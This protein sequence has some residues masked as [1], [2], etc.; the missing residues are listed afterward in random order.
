MITLVAIMLILRAR[1][2][3]CQ[4]DESFY[5][6]LAQR[7]Y[8]GD[9]LIIDEWHPAQFY[10]P[11]LLP[12][13]AAYRALVPSQTGILFAAR[14]SCILI[15]YFAALLSF[16]TA[17]R[18][19]PV[20]ASC[21]AS[22]LYLVYA[23]QNI[24]GFSYYSLFSA[25]SLISLTLLVRGLRG[26]S[27]PNYIAAGLFS[28]LTVLCMP[29]SAPLFILIG[30]ALVLPQGVRRKAADIG[31]RRAYLLTIV[32]SA[33][34]YIIFFIPKVPVRT[35]LQNLQYI[36]N[37]PEHDAS[38]FQNALLTVKSV[39]RVFR[40]ELIA[41][42]IACVALLGIRLASRGQSAENRCGFRDF[43][44]VCMI[45]AF[46]ACSFFSWRDGRS[47]GAYLYVILPLLSLP[48]YL[49]FP[50][51]PRNFRIDEILF[52]G[53]GILAVLFACGSNTH[54]SCLGTGC[55]ISTMGVILGCSK[56]LEY[57][58]GRPFKRLLT[59]AFYAFCIFM[60]F[61]ALY[62]RM[63][64]VYR[65]DRIDALHIKITA[66]PAAGLI[67]TSRHAEEYQQVCGM[68]DDLYRQYPDAT[69]FFCKLL[70]W[71]YFYRDFHCCAP[72]AWR[73][74][75]SSAHLTSYIGIHGGALPQ[76]VV[77]FHDEIGNYK[78]DQGTNLTPNEND[79]DAG[80]IPILLQ[81]R[82]RHTASACAEIYIAPD[83][84]PGA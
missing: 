10:S 43:T 81:H 49:I 53:G 42:F 9:A 68:L 37:D 11:V 26:G 28:S 83:L 16:L 70:P 1:Y 34:L 84:V 24:L 13:Y 60:T 79:V 63:N 15:S 21:F 80:L 59:L 65:D 5:L 33:L 44:A 82:Y 56:Y 73:T 4:S 54:V 29:T 19:Y 14:V 61:T 2:S 50:H 36:L 35:L 31:G 17:R 3:F 41:A 72:T 6:A 76:I 67:T 12:W 30:L 46:I 45:P 8:M 75:L 38:I 74:P 23:R 58:P 25:F 27:R 71:A 20:W 62:S 77:V 48:A 52:W 66:G 64:T 18:Y 39:R 47:V 22:V 40:P 57:R 51:K 7:L 78:G 69:F 55:C 32:F